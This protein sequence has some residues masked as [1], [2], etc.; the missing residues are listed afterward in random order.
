[1]P[2]LSGLEATE[3]IR[4]AENETGAHIPI[5]ALTAHAMKEDRD[6]CLEAGM[7]DFLSKPVRAEELFDLVE[8]VRERFSLEPR[9]AEPPP[10]PQ[11]LD[12]DALL[13]GVRGDEKLLAELVALFREDAGE[14]LLDIEEAIK[15]HDANS[16]ASSAH[17]F[18]GS[19]GNFA[20]RGA[21]NK[22]REIERQARAGDL[23]G[24]GVLF[25]ALVKET[26][27]LEKTLNELIDSN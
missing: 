23:T 3:A 21:Y 22:A 10:A 20:S 26:R 4:K 24:C 8:N 14:M 5:V 1:M 6:R 16:L 15:H 11:V 13:A 27:R 7:D 25:A 19:L 17:A 12:R 9:L 2:E 18:V